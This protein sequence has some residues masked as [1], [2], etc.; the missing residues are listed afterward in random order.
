MRHY[1][2]LLSRGLGVALEFTVGSLRFLLWLPYL[3]RRLVAAPS[4]QNEEALN[5]ENE[6]KLDQFLETRFINLDKR[7][8][9][10]SQI[11][12]ELRKLSFTTGERFKAIEDD[13]GSLGCA[14]SHIAVLSRFLS[15]DKR[16]I[17]VCED[18]LEFLGTPSQ[19]ESAIQEFSET[20]LLDVL[21]LS[22]R[23]RAPQIPL[24]TTLSIGN[25]IQTTACY[26]AKRKAARELLTNFRESEELLRIGIEPAEASIDVRWKKLQLKSLVF[27]VPRAPLARQ[28]ESYSD[29]VRKIKRYDP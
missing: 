24:T 10:L 4:N 23:L 8:D 2:Y 11:E 25:S 14:S 19:I 16:L 7:K 12:T 26:I 5:L 29:I 21:C 27:A 18:D 9:R 1:R 3:L 6:E 15:S 17:M 28:R 13:N 20:P 22:Y